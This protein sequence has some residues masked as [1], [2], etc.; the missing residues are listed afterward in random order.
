MIYVDHCKRGC[1]RH[2][3]IYFCSAIYGAADFDI[4]EGVGGSMVGAGARPRTYL[5]I[6][7]MWSYIFFIKYEYGSYSLSVY[8]DDDS[9]VRT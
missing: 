3:F 2:L 4:H 6:N 1:G 9:D 8:V 7:C 5:T